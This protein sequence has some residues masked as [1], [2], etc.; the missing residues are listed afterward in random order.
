MTFC[1]FFLG[2]VFTP[3]QKLPT[4]AN[5]RLND[6]GN[7]IRTLAEELMEKTKSEEFSASDKSI[8]GALREQFFLLSCL[9]VLIRYIVR[10]QNA[11]SKIRMD[12]KE[13]M[14]QV[15]IFSFPLPQRTHRKTRL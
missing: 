10:S 1:S 8:I 4:E 6:L 12:L 7:T 14:G 3:L 13:V 15:S 11:S 9:H 5:T 2:H